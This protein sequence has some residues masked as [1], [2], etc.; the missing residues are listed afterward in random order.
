MGE[1]N[2]KNK[3]KRVSLSCVLSVQVDLNLLQVN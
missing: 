1:M 3:S 2:E